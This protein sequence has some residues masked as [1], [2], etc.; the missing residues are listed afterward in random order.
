MS[1]CASAGSATNTGGVSCT[2]KIIMVTPPPLFGQHITPFQSVALVPGDRTIVTNLTMDAE[3]ALIDD[4]FEFSKEE[5][6]DLLYGLSK[7][8]NSFLTKVCYC[9]YTTPSIQ[10]S[11]IYIHT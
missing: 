8:Y 11:L 6:A 3:D 4:R 9:H 5:V 1:V 7:E 10:S 2:E